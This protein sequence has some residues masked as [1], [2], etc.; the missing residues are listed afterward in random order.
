MNNEPNTTE[1]ILHY[2]R[3]LPHWQPESAMFFVTLRLANSLP[4]HIVQ[5]LQATHER[6]QPIIHAK[7]SSADQAKERHTL[8]KKYFE[9]FDAWL[10][11][12]INIKSALAGG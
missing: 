9:H 6:E 5:V 1:R 2:R 12:C 8:D 7:A 10:D 11:R 4:S 3:R